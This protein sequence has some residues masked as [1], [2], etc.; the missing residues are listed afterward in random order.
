LY[1]GFNIFDGP[2][3]EP[4]SDAPHAGHPGAREPDEREPREHAEEPGSAKGGHSGE[5]ATA[6]IFGGDRAHDVGEADPAVVH[7]G[8]VRR[9]V[10]F[11]VLGGLAIFVLALAGTLFG[12]GVRRPA[13]KPTTPRAAME[14]GQDKR[15]AP[16]PSQGRDFPPARRAPRPQARPAP[17]SPAD[18]AVLARPEATAVDRPPFTEAPTGA[19]PRPP[20]PRPAPA[21]PNREFDFERSREFD[22]ER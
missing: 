2:E 20:A 5:V 1:E 17:S 22:F 14:P 4:G 15:P 9:H 18:V 3:P 13:G 16:K 6:E 10:R 7:S 19:S 11:L 21:P 8:A 12:S